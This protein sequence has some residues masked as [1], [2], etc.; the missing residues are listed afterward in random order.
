[1]GLVVKLFLITLV[2]P[3]I[4][5]DWFLPFMTNFFHSPSLTPWSKHLEV[6]GLADF[7]YGPIMIIVQLPTTYCGWLLDQLAST[8]YFTGLGFRIGILVAD[9]F[10]L[11]ALVQQFESVRKQLIIFYWLSPLILFVNYWHGSLDVV[12]VVLF[13]FSIG[14]LRYSKQN[15]GGLFLGLAVATKHSILIGTPFVF[16]YLWLRRGLGAGIKRAFLIFLMT[17]VILEG[18]LFFSS[19]FVE[20]VIHNKE[21]GKLF[22][23]SLEMGENLF[24]YIIPALYMV[25]LYFTWRMQ[26]INSD[27]LMATLGVAFSIIVIST[28]A[29]PGWFAWLVPFHALHQ[30]RNGSGGAIILVSALSLVFIVYHFLFSAGAQII[31]S[32][33]MTLDIEQQIIGS[34]DGRF[35]SLLYTLLTGIG[36]IVALQMLREGIRENDYYRLGQKPLVVGIG[37]DSCTGKTTFAG[38]LSGLFGNLSSVHLL[39]DDYHNWDRTSPM[40]RS[41]TPLNPRA[42]KLFEL[43]RDLR[44]LLNGGIVNV[45]MYNHETGRFLPAKKKKTR[46]IIFV[47][48]L[49]ALFP[50]E[51]VKEMGVCF[52]LEVEESLRTEWKVVRD[53]GKRGRSREYT[54]KEMER[55]FADAE[56]YIHPQASRADVIF[57]LHPVNL[58]MINEGKNNNKLKLC[59]SMKSGIYYAD[60]TR[61]LIGVCGLHININKVNKMGGVDLVIQGVVR[62]EDIALASRMLLP[63]LG[64]LMDAR[65]G[66]SDGMLGVM[67]LIALVEINE[68]LMQRRRESI[69]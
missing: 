17:L 40:W 66:F 27:L 68:S 43:V 33:W 26:R 3:T 24:I 52:Y 18:P 60:L 67:Q 16:I 34:F 47:S 21:V 56:N 12:P 59:V 45:R 32:S 50:N 31:N 25:L 51:L 4:H 55:R 53:A 69:V 2:V 30:S 13:L 29:P 65:E 15:Y 1:V 39:G 23:L 63:Q 37:G 8:Q 22:W 14:Y 46:N 64:E 19:G 61:S 42:N 48:G 44:G 62:G 10:V 28:P 7:P 20:M 54:I 11:L 38:A 41:I 9:L 36:A 58:N 57:S 49:H 5:Q 6:G 35:Q